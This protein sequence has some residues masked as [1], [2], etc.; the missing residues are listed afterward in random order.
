MTIVASIT[1]LIRGLV[2]FIYRNDI[3]SERGGLALPATCGTSLRTSPRFDHRLAALERDRVEAP[4]R[5][6]E[7]RAVIDAGRT[8]KVP[9][10]RGRSFIPLG[11]AAATAIAFIALNIQ[12]G[13]EDPSS[14]SARRLPPSCRCL[15]GIVCSC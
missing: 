1:R 10:R 7:C 13:C 11:V 8:V 14:A 3:P 5:L 12:R 2:R 9:V 4:G 15:R 6:H